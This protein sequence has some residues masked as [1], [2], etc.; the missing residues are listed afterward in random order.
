[1]FSGC[2]MYVE[3]LRRTLGFTNKDELEDFV[4]GVKNV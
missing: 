4:H 1:M 2:V 3:T